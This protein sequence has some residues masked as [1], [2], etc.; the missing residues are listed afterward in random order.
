MNNKNV[1]LDGDIGRL[2]QIHQLHLGLYARVAKKLRISASYVSLVARQRRENPK[3]M[4]ELAKELRRM[5]RT[6][7]TRIG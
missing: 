3:I 5:S 4:G 2:P 6:K 1:K 7:I